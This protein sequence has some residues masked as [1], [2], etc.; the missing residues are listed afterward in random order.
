MLPQVEK[1]EEEKKTDVCRE[2][3]LV[4]S[5]IQTIWKHRTKII[6]AFEHNGPR[7]K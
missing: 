7:I 4:N 2:F 5:K 6:G 1:L 3:G